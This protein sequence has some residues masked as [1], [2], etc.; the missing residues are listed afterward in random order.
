MSRL[1]ASLYPKKTRQDF[2]DLLRYGNI[3]KEPEEYITRVFFISLIGGFALTLFLRF[4]LDWSI[5]I[6]IPASFLLINGVFYTWLNLNADSRARYV[7]NLLPDVLQ[8][9]ASN[10][11]A[12]LTIDRAL[13]LAA[14]PEFGQFKDDINR[15]GKEI[16][17]GKEVGEALMDMGKSIKSERLQKTFQLIVSAMASGGQLADLLQQ[18]ALNL[19]QQ[20]LVEQRVRVSVLTYVIFIFSAIGF[21]APMLFSLSTFLVEVITDIFS[22]VQLPT[23][24][25]AT[26]IPITFSKITITPKF[27]NAYTISSLMLTSLLGS[28]I[29]GLI[30]KGKEKEGLKYVPVLIIMTLTLF[31]LIKYVMGKLLGGLF[32][33]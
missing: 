10:L 22:K 32:N 18:T 12:G 3:P 4:F 33:I 23:A 16:A 30:S 15:V 2:A 27:L 25:V 8:L 20:K 11:R 5:F 26:N 31:F 21:G 28:L 19:R 24:N 6:L 29:L 13:L 14:R 9:M 1:I 7:E 17:T